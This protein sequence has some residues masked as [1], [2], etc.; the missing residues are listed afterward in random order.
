M[1]GPD[2]GSPAVWGSKCPQVQADAGSWWGCW[3]YTVH[4]CTWPHTLSHDPGAWACRS[5]WL[6]PWQ[7]LEVGQRPARLGYPASLATCVSG[8]W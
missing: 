6:P 4:R 2:S 5:G 8:H 3:C 7:L 1:V